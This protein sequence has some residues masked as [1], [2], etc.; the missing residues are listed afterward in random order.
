MSY[1]QL[2]RLS[3][4]VFLLCC[5]CGL[6]AFGQ[7]STTYRDTLK[8]LSKMR[9]PNVDKEELAKLFK[10][11]DERITDLVKALDDPQPDISRRAQI[12][13]RYL[14][15][16]IGVMGLYEW[17]SRKDQF[18][19]AGPIPIPLSEWDYKVISTSYTGS[20]RDWTRAE[21]YIFALALDDSPRA[22]NALEELIRGKGDLSEPTVIN[23]AIKAVRTS[24]PAKT[25]AGKKVLA[26]LVLKNAFFVSPDDW[27]YASAR[28]LALNGAKDKGLVEVYINRGVLSE[29]WYHVVVQ[30]CE[31]GWRFFSVT[32]VAVS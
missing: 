14:G 27:K 18:P 31:K 11:G 17:Y 22:R 30:K 13:I 21:P 4:L 15:N 29:E 3:L 24:Q 1:T 19:V 28:L 32:P 6:T 10:I 25:L 26:E 5:F 2:I 7:S 20:K 8:L 16:T 9:S 12:V 23:H